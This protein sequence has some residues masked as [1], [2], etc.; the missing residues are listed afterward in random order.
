MIT[1]ELETDRIFF[2]TPS[3]ITYPV[4]TYFLWIIFLIIMP[5]LFQNLLVSIS[6]VWGHVLEKFYAVLQIEQKFLV[7]ICYRLMAT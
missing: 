4:V 6:L 5:M 2:S 3:V 7:A 1:G